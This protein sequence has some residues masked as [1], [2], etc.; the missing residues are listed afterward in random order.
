MMPVSTKIQ[1]TIPKPA[2][3]A[4]GKDDRRPKRS[5]TLARAYVPPT[6]ISRMS[7]GPVKELKGP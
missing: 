7:P 2:T 4:H 3:A 6:A 1:M 5:M